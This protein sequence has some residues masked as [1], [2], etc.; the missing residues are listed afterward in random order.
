MPLS[1][2]LYLMSLILF[3]QTV[4]SSLRR[5]GAT[6]GY[7]I[8]RPQYFHDCKFIDIRLQIICNNNIVF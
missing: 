4:D 7:R 8:S 2:R 1:Y 5:S 6:Q 3:Y